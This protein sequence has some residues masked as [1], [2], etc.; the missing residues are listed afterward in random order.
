MLSRDGE[1]G[2]TTSVIIALSA[3]KSNVRGHMAPAILVLL[4]FLWFGIMGPAVMSE[5][6]ARAAVKYR[7]KC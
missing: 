5:R 2:D 6:P 1:E 7:P 4:F 3:E